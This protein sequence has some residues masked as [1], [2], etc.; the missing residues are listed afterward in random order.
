MDASV[1]TFLV[2][3]IPLLPNRS[4]APGAE[5]EARGGAVKFEGLMVD[6]AQRS[7][8]R[9][10]SRRRLAVKLQ[11]LSCCDMKPSRIS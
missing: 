10:N 9:A 11:T 6:Y 8:G 1:S 7:E 5:A 2:R 3:I 4:I